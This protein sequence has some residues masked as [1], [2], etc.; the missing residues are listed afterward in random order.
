MGSRSK[1]L[2]SGFR[3]Q[4]LGLRVEGYGFRGLRF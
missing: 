1:I 4:G 3:V 2:D